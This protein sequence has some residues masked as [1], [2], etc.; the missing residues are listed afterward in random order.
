MLTYWRTAQGTGYQSNSSA[1]C[2]PGNDQNGGTVGLLPSWIWQQ[3]LNREARGFL[4]E[5]NS[6][7]S[8]ASRYCFCRRLQMCVCLCVSVS[9]RT[10]SRKLLVENRCNL[11]GICL[12]GNARS[13]GK[14]VTFDFDLWP[15][16][17]F[18][19]IF[20]SPRY[21]FRMALP[22]NFIFDTEIHL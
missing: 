7:H 12:T 18:T 3:I 13:I 14:L 16:E 19:R 20:F 4:F 22:S 2:R 21:T 1:K 15:W 17:L 6:N 10:K 9:V 5:F 8:S 11:V